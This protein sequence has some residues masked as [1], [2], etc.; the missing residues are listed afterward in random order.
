MHYYCRQDENEIFECFAHKYS[1]E[2]SSSIKGRKIYWLT[3][4]LLWL[5]SG[6]QKR[7][8][9]W[10]KMDLREVV[11]W[12]EWSWIIS[13]PRSRLFLLAFWNIWA[14]LIQKELKN[15]TSKFRG[16]Y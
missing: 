11:L 4:K 7:T 3:G 15:M 6:K 2:H 10:H 14:L 12:R 1:D 13:N 9:S 16:T 5:L 8:G